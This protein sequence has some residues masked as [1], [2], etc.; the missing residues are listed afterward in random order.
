MAKKRKFDLQKALDEL[1][2]YDPRQHSAGKDEFTTEMHD[3]LDVSAEDEVKHSVFAY[4][5]MLTTEP[6]FSTDE[7][8]EA[9][10]ITT[11]DIRKY[12]PEWLALRKSSDEE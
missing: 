3:T 8:M 4:L 2:D 12:R 11:A 5:D 6:N 7:E 9:Y 10:G 1:G